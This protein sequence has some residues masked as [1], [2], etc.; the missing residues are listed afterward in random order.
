MTTIKTQNL[1]AL[2]N[3][4]AGDY[5]VGE[6]ISGTTGLF[7]VAGT[8]TGSLV[9]ASAPT[10]TSP[11]FITPILGIPTSGTLTN[12]IGLPVSTGISGL[13][14]G[15]A[16]FLATP[17]SANFA[18]TLT[19]ETGTGS[20]VFANTPTL[21][22]PILGTPT[23]GT[24]TNCTGLPISTGVTGL[25]ANV[26]TFLATPS[27]A[28]L[29]TAL[30]DETGTGSLVF[31]TSPTL[32][33]PLL[34]T[35]T[36]GTLTNCTGLPISS[37]V[38]GLAA[39]VATFLATPSSANLISALT[40][41][42]GSGAAVFAT[43]PTLVTPTLGAALATSV[44][45]GSS[46]LLDNSGNH[47]FDLTATGSAN[48]LTLANA[49]TSGTPSFTATGSDSNITVTLDSK[50]TGAINIK[51]TGTND[52]A[53]AGY[54]GEIIT[55]GYVTGVAITSNTQTNITSISLTAGDWDIYGSF[56]GVPAATTTQS[57]LFGSI[58][59]T[60]AT[61]TTPSSD[62]QVAIAANNPWYT[63]VPTIR[64]SISATTTIYLVG[65]IVYA[66]STLTASG[67]ISGRRVR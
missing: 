34:G 13:G 14:T 40:D 63:T 66:V 5:L 2:G 4:A 9:F 61:I 36:S 24:L 31:G 45:L 67:V 8:G 64:I 28:N 38:S 19:D 50:G 51:G 42:T 23:S 22:T 65:L 41:E 12:C 54:V 10:L 25:A 55:S 11:T 39:N 52:S 16:T 46:G 15:V 56:G 35:P 30:T 20:A 17:S 47:I 57:R 7:S 37:G 44:Q 62:F 49:A 27:S 43:S 53:T 59:S 26:A 33:T 6:R 21:V 18:A 1:T 32:T 3:L 58:S 48:Y 60:S 29:I